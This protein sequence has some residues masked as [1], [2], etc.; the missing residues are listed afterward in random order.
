MPAAIARR[1]GASAAIY[2]VGG[3]DPLETA[4]Q[5][6]QGETYRSNYDRFLALARRLQRA[7]PDQTIALPLER[8]GALMGVH[9]TAAGL[10]RKE[11]V[12]NG[13]LEPAGE[14]V[15][16]RR[17]GLYRFSEKA[18]NL[19]KPH[20]EHLTNPRGSRELNKP[21]RGRGGAP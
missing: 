1:R 12:A 6:I 14:Y 17:A 8:I 20:T 11:A 13:C 16:H 9:H 18:K 21:A 15:P 5:A 10:Y 3:P 7:R 19:A 4:W 2:Q